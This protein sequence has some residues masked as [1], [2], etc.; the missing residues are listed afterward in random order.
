MSNELLLPHVISQ[1]GARL[2]ASQLLN[3]HRRQPPNYKG[4]GSKPHDKQSDYQTR[5]LHESESV[6]LFGTDFY[7]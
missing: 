5:E 1:N 4:P 3:L 7:G 2:E 6:N